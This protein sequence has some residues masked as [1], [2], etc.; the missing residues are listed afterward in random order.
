M[1]ANTRVPYME[2]CAIGGGARAYNDIGAQPEICEGAVQLVGC[3][4]VCA[5]TTTATTAATAPIITFVDARP[6]WTS[7]PTTYE[8][9]EHAECLCSQPLDRSAANG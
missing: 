8:H 6:T 2:G 9:I 1:E 4:S 3:S 7:I 5:A